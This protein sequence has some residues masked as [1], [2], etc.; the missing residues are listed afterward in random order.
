MKTYCTRALKLSTI[1]KIM[2]NY[3][4]LAQKLWLRKWK[5][6][7]EWKKSKNVSITWCSQAVTHPSTNHARRC[8]T[9]VIGRELV[10]S[11]WYERWQERCI[12]NAYI[13]TGGYFEKLGHKKNWNDAVKIS[14]LAI[15]LWGIFFVCFVGVFFSLSQKSL[16]Y[17][18][19]LNK[20]CIFSFLYSLNFC[21]LVLETAH[22]TCI[23]KLKRRRKKD[24][25]YNNENKTCSA[26]MKM[27]LF[28]LSF[29]HL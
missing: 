10:F 23:V 29:S 4:F 22:S 28:L 12:L 18:L 15:Q 9:S 26:A 11:T 7:K 16:M 20:F 24:I 2:G 19:Q 21:F 27:Y 1:S 17:F 3:M 6:I 8:L 5:R 25:P 13:F 14:M